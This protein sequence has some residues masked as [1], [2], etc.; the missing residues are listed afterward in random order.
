[1]KRWRSGL[2]IRSVNQ[3]LRRAAQI[4]KKEFRC[5]TVREIEFLAEV[6]VILAGN[7]MSVL[8]VEAGSA[9]NTPQIRSAWSRKKELLGSYLATTI[10]AQ[11]EQKLE[12]CN[13]TLHKFSPSD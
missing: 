12:V 9:C 2:R 10:L 8:K 6:I 7:R 11:V 4:H 13:F 3:R 1:M 5:V